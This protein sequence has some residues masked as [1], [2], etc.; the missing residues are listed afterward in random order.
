MAFLRSIFTVFP[1][2]FIFNHL[3]GSM[4]SQIIPVILPFCGL[5]LAF[6]GL[7]FLGHLFCEE[8]R[9][10]LLLRHIHRR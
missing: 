4:I 3:S 7:S 6:F 2:L 8:P 1:F 5:L 9:M 10:A